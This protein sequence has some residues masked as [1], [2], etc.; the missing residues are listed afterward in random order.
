MNRN[1][2]TIR[3][4]HIGVSE[5]VEGDTQIGTILLNFLVGQRLDP[6]AN[7]ALISDVKGGRVLIS[8]Y[9]FD[10]YEP[11][12]ILPGSPDLIL[13]SVNFENNED[14]RASILQLLEYLDGIVNKSYDDN[15]IYEKATYE[16]E[17]IPVFEDTIITS[18]R[19][20]PRNGLVPPAVTRTVEIETKRPIRQGY[21]RNPSVFT[22]S[23]TRRGK[24]TEEVYVREVFPRSPVGSIR[25]SGY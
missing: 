19:V 21:D 16:L 18:S 25:G 3:V 11:I 17:R 6:N 4:S 14:K 13:T 7:V 20:G 1:R 2:P 23:D 12:S 15:N 8:L 24:T 5:N 9:D 22:P 10:L